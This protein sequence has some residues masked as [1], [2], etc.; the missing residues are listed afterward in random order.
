MVSSK[1]A[2]FH[3]C[4]SAGAQESVGGGV[5][6][7][8]TEEEDHGA[9]AMDESAL[10]ETFR[11][12][13]IVVLDGVLAGSALESFR[14]QVSRELTKPCIPP[15][16]GTPEG[17]RLSSPETWPRGSQRRVIEVVP[18][19]V[20][21]HWGAL[22]ASPKL[23]HALDALLG[24]DAWELPSNQPHGGPC[25]IRHWYCPVVFPESSASSA[26]T[27]SDKAR[28]ATLYDDAS[29][30]RR[31][32]VGKG[33]PPWSKQEDAVLYA[34]RAEDLPWESVAAAVGNGRTPKQCRERYQ[35]PW[36]AEDDAALL[37]LC[38]KHEGSWQQITNK[39]QPA[40]ACTKRQVRERAA[41]LARL[42]GD[43]KTTTREE[44]GVRASSPPTR[45]SDAKPAWVPVN[46]RRVRG[47]GWH[48]DI[49]PGFDTD[50]ARHVHGD[51][52]Q[53]CVALVLLSD[54]RAGGG[55]TAFVAGSHA[56][57]G[58]FL[59][60]RAPQGVRHQELNAWAIDAVTDAAKR[61][62]LPL[63]YEVSEPNAAETK[64]ETKRKPRVG[65]VD[66]IV[67]AA[68][69]VALLHPWLVHSGTTNMSTDPR[70]MANGMVR[71]R[72]EA[73]ER[74]GGV[75][76]LRGLEKW[77]PRGP[78]PE[79][80]AE[81]PNATAAPAADAAVARG[82]PAKAG[83][84]F[85]D[86]LASAR[87]AAS[88]AASTRAA[89][90][91]ASPIDSETPSVSVVVPAHDAARWLD[92]CFASVV[93]QT[94]PYSRLE[95]SA[96]DD[97]SSDDTETVIKA[98]AR[99][100]SE[101]GIA[102]AVSGSRWGPLGGKPRDS[103]Q[104]HKKGNA[105]NDASNVAR[106]LSVALAK[107]GG[108]GHGK[109]AAVRQSAGEVLVFLDAD[110]IMTP[111]R[112]Q[113]QVACV[114]RN[115]EAIVG[116][117]WRRHPAGSTE[118]YERWANAL[119]DPAGLWLEQFRET[120]VQMPTWCLTRAA[121]DKVGGFDEVPPD[122]GEGEDLVFFHKHLDAFDAEETRRALGLGRGEGEGGK[123]KNVF[124]PES[125]D[126][127]SRAPRLP[128]R[129]AV[130]APGAP[131][132][133]LYRWSPDSGTSRVSRQRLLEIRVAAFR[134][135]VLST[136][137]WRAFA[138]WG[139]G[140]DAKAFANAL[141]GATRRRIVAMLDVDRNK[142]GRSYANHRWREEAVDEVGVQTTAVE[143]PVAHFEDHAASES[144]RRAREGGAFRATP[145]VVCV[146]KRRK[147]A[148]EA[149]DLER[150]VRTLGLT[151]GDTL[152]YFM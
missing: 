133:L 104:S 14:E 109:N 92:E 123:R 81:P 144:A 49:G 78:G 45:N 60:S 8:G 147:G 24:A 38:S 87:A 131:P 122:R 121:Y 138:V 47:K 73:F 31:G 105:T 91:A 39:M 17:V 115:K 30:W 20:G 13:G 106:D 5:S 117:S 77:A 61:G 99:V 126:A 110:D 52:C 102:V 64:T 96:Y 139:A 124:S 82:V 11:R 75:A 4:Q 48:V 41:A 51:P 69:S 98:W 58:S 3:R 72:P 66:Q 79:P 71:V 116:G 134:R 50:A 149:G 22:A 16:S 25:A 97:A 150:N 40:R 12:D 143:I 148:G 114:L 94:Y 83:M 36:T 65:V 136:P 101:L 28:G 1:K 37:E 43:E 146:A 63:K 9:V 33:A 103:I 142:C 54:W 34:S 135:R 80:D 120:T 56:W 15:E 23:R 141:D 111:R 67:G 95:V 119:P 27:S 93:A 53:G 35:P 85:E 62:L 140:R 107:P 118:H 100:F 57:V 59:Q 55:G 44:K 7:R 108:I 89:A 145:V 130:S 32:D 88:A 129:R 84:T 19:G 86:A 74:D 26:A 112:V 132:L 113:T 68:G 128:L 127:V 137:A 70:L 46:R 6:R 10:R 21:E 42:R 90:S 2:L 76:V 18:P 151:E 125:D 29:S 152:W